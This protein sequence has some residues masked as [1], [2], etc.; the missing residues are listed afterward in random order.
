VTS[1]DWSIT[2]GDKTWTR[3]DRTGAHWSLITLGLGAQTWN[4]EPSVGPIA[5]LANLAAFISIDEQRPFDQ[6]VAE[7]SALSETELLAAFTPG[8]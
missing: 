7:L 4:I 2:W 3:T 6:V 1:A 8:V 5:F